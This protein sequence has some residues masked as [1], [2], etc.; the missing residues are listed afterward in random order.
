[1]SGTSVEALKQMN[2]VDFLSQQYGLKLRRCG[3]EYKCCS[4]FT[5]ETNPSFFVRLVQGHWLFKDFSSGE[6]GSIFDFVQLK[7]KLASFAEAFAFVRAALKSL[8]TYGRHAD[9]SVD[10]STSARADRPHD[11][12]CL[13][14]RF[15]QNDPG[16]CR[17][18]LV[19][20][21]ITPA[22]VDTLIADG[23]VVHNLLGGRSFCCF[24]VRDGAGQL[25]CLDNHAIDGTKKFVLGSKRPFS[26]EWET[27]KR[28]K[29]VFL[30][31]G[32]IDYLSIKSLELE[33]LPGL[34][35]LGN[36]LNFERELLGN[37]ERIVSAM[38]NDTGGNSAFLDLVDRYSDK[39]VRAYD[40][41]GHKDPNE[42]LVA[43][44]SGKGRTLSA[45]RKLQLYREFQRVENRAEL[46]RHW[47]IDRSYLY[48]VVR[49]AE[50]TLLASMEERKLGR[51]PKG[52]PTTLAEAQER[53]KELERQYEKEAKE[54][55]LLSCR[56][57]L[58]AIRLKW[59]EIEA[60]EARGEKVNEETG[61]ETKHQVKKKRNRRRL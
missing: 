33:P 5:A 55:E 15:R 19:G 25:Q 13:Y 27:V 16:V 4:P 59:A 51:P 22:L 38:D 20:R 30:T 48:E 10:A 45:K 32:I 34:A 14:Q 17:E 28:A 3:T 61:P 2:L 56:T 53:I 23:T 6:G 40:L 57:E 46:A 49:D 18:Y 7:E 44:R 8:A 58:M 50:E 29:A 9:Q 24:A 21:S 42:L 12:E 11:V 52:A 47:G 1:M 41:E 37:A 31:E 54:R 43:V 26:C 35:L 36:Q 60:A 39:E